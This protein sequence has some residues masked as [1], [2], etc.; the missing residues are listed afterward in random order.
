MSFLSSFSGGKQIPSTANLEF[1]WSGCRCNPTAILSKV[2]FPISCMQ[3]QIQVL[4]HQEYFSVCWT[5]LQPKSLL[6]ESDLLVSEF[7]GKEENYW[8]V[9][10]FIFLSMC[11]RK[12]KH[13]LLPGS[14]GVAHSTTPPLPD[15]KNKSPWWYFK[16]AALNF[17]ALPVKIKFLKFFWNCKVI[18]CT[19]LHEIMDLWLSISLSCFSVVPRDSAAYQKAQKFI[20]RL[21]FDQISSLKVQP[22]AMIHIL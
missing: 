7:L 1:V 17:I 9:G 2:Y 15:S 13:S 12:K 22:A 14:K 18:G 16:D 11:L 10:P 8:P 19:E 4:E 20:N 5:I 6:S 3:T 21:F